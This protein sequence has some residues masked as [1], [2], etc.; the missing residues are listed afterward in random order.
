MAAKPVTKAA[1]KGSSVAKPSS[2]STA[3]KVPAASPSKISAASKPAS[4]K[5]TPITTAPSSTSNPTS[6]P[7]SKTI[8]AKS[9]VASSTAATKNVAKAGVKTATPASKGAKPVAK[10]KGAVVPKAESAEAQ[11][12]SKAAVVIQKWIRRFLAIRRRAHLVA[13]KQDYEAAIKKAEKDA[14][15][16]MVKMER[17]E[18]EK[19]MAVEAEKKRKIKEQKQNETLLREAAFDGSQDELRRIIAMGVN[20][21]CTDSNGDTPLLEA[22]GS[23]QVD[24]IKILCDLHANVNARGKFNRTPLF[25]AAFGGH[26]AAVSLLLSYGADPRLYDSDGVTPGE[27]GSNDETVTTLAKWDIKETEKLLEAISKRNE[28]KKQQEMLEKQKITKT[29]QGK[30]EEAK[31][32]DTAKQAALKSAYCEYEKRICEHDKCIRKHMEERIITLILQAVKDAELELEAVKESAR[33]AREALQQLKFQLREEESAQS[34]ELEQRARCN[35]RE[36]DDVVMRDVGNKIGNDSKWPLLIDI[37]RQIATFLRYRDTNYINACSPVDTV[38]EKI[39]L[40]LL[41]AMRFGKPLVIDMMDVDFWHALPSIFNVVKP[42]LLADIVSKKILS[43]DCIKPLLKPSDGDE[44]KLANFTE[45]RLSRFRVFFVTL[46]KFPDA[47][48]LAATTALEIIP[49]QP[50]S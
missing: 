48:L 2:E 13:K 35:I 24:M 17:L 16:L 27:I 20:I 36:V 5:A 33:E 25:R 4:V 9:S 31:K 45:D 37:S 44:F 6:K 21:D 46:L 10:G 26:V 32:I 8:A 15:L 49:S 14:W 12:L 7:P 42:N 38:P 34:G 47:E 22:S 19:R 28:E 50:T 1:E 30:L 39:R 40:A 11:R 41:G 43:P 3:K 23:G 18:E 29:V